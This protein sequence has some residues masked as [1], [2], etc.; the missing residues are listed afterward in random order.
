MDT[1]YQIIVFLATCI[2]LMLFAV[3]LIYILIKMLIAFYQGIPLPESYIQ[4]Y[5]DPR[6][7]NEKTT[8]IQANELDADYA[9]ITN[10]IDV[11]YKKY[12]MDGTTKMSRYQQNDA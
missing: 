8:N 12:I 9:S 3:F 10:T 11:Q 2:P 6:E 4:M 7:D 1:R 5:T